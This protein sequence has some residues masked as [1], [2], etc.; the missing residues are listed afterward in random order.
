MPS[1]LVDG[2]DVDGDHLKLKGE[3]LHHLRVRRHK[4]G[5]HIEIIDGQGG[6]YSVRLDA[7]EQDRAAGT[8]LERSPERGEPN[9]ELTVACALVK[10]DRFDSAVEKI[11]EVGARK[12]VPLKCKRSVVRDPS[13]ARLERWRRI[14]QAA[15]KQSGRSRIPQ[16]MEPVEIGAELGGGLPEGALRLMAVAR[17]GVPSLR[18]A[19]EGARSTEEV[20]L[21]I[22]PEGGF[23]PEEEDEAAAAGVRPFTWGGD[24]ALRVD[25][26]AVVL[27]GLVL[28]ELGGYGEEDELPPH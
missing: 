14:A 24:H 4:V 7:I 13:E 3:E 20:T 10:G 5:D 1:F 23:A 9:V 27:G 22:G 18:Q 21:F 17:G 16:V 8:I 6:F 28:F 11:T 2:S 12:I 15:A 26:A 25:T 19:V